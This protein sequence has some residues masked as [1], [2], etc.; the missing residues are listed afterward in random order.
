M[1]SWIATQADY[2][3]AV[4]CPVMRQY[5]ADHPG[6]TR[7][8]YGH[9]GIHHAAGAVLPDLVTASL[10]NARLASFLNMLSL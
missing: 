9:R 6:Y 8:K 10:I 7:N 1:L 3:I 2:L 5:F 4:S